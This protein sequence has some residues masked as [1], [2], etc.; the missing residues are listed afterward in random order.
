MAFHKF[1]LLILLICLSIDLQGQDKNSFTDPRDGRNYA[2]VSI[3]T[4]TWMSENLTWLPAVFPVNDSQFDLPCFY[5]YGYNG[6]DTALARKSGYYAHYGTLYNFT[7]A[8]EACP[9]GWH[10]PTDGEWRVLEEFLGMSKDESGYRDWRQ[11]GQVGKQTKSRAGW[12]NGN[13][14]NQSGLSL[15]PGGCRGYEGFQSEGFC[16]YYWTSSPCGG[17]NGWRRGF[18]GDDNGSSRQDER[19]YFGCSIRCIKDK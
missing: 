6:R 18:C 10:L 2:A 19:R 11:T 7:A 1:L 5:V 3:G 14:E 13:G 16:G 15:L 9:P 17:D 4:Q 8:A 12:K